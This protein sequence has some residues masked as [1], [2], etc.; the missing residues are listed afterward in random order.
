[1]VKFIQTQANRK[2]GSQW[3]AVEKIVWISVVKKKGDELN[4]GLHMMSGETISIRNAHL[5][6]RILEQLEIPESSWEQADG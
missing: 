4:I 6:S 2:G 5:A 3:A 1:M